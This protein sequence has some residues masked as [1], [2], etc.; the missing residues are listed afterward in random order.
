MATHFPALALDLASPPPR[1]LADALPGTGRRRSAS[2]SAS[3]AASISSRE[4]RAAPRSASSASSPFSTAWRKAVAAIADDGLAQH[5]A[6]R[7]RRGAAPR[8]AAG[9]LA[10]R[11]STFSIPTRGRSGG[12]G[13]GASSARPISTASPGHCSPAACFASP[14]TSR[15]TPPGRSGISSRGRISTWTAERADDW[16]LPFPAWSGTRYETKAVAAGRKPT[17]LSFKRL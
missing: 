12:T 3:A 1:R 4:A 2:R 16:R 8:L 11:A 7:R 15:A 5:P 14:A 13:S 10:R 17:Y 6:L 9:R